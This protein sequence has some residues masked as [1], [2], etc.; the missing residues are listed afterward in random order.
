[1]LHKAN[2][3]APTMLQ[4]LV[5]QF[6]EL[7]R[8]V[9]KEVAQGSLCDVLPVLVFAST[10]ASL[11]SFRGAISGYTK[12]GDITLSQLSVTEMQAIL[13]DLLSRMEVIQHRNPLA[14]RAFRKTLVSLC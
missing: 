1:M 13:L 9:A 10:R 5:I 7:R 2:D 3:D 8:C 11:A 12:V 14:C 6:I 4:H